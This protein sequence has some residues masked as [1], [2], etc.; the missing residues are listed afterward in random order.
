MIVLDVDD[1]LGERL[2]LETAAPE[3]AGIGEERSGGDA[4]HAFRALVHPPGEEAGAVREPGRGGKAQSSGSLGG[5]GRVGSAAE[6]AEAAEQTPGQADGT[7]ADAAGKQAGRWGLG[8]APAA[9][10]PP[11]SQPEYLQGCVID[12]DVL[13]QTL[14]YLV[15]KRDVCKWKAICIHFCFAR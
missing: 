11:T 3:P 7:A 12:I 8:W 13:R 1:E 9:W 10:W 4:R 15:L 5:G 2:E 6:S 14:V